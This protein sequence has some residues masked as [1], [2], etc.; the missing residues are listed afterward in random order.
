MQIAWARFAQE[1]R[2][3]L[4]FVGPYQMFN[5]DVVAREISPLSSFSQ[6]YHGYFK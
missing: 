2:A 4:L 1:Y 3:L 5:I 6:S